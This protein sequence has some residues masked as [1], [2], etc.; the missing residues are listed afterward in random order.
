MFGCIFQLSPCAVAFGAP[1]VPSWHLVQLRT[2]CGK[3]AFEKS[4]PLT[5]YGVPATTLGRLEPLWIL[6]IITLKSTG[7]LEAPAT[8]EPGLWQVTHN[9][10]STRVPCAVSWLWQS[11][12]LAVATISRLV[13]APPAGTKS[14]TPLAFG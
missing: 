13:P 5:T 11:L 3:T 1:G 2:S 7:V 10:V 14:N 8:H 6:W 12:H 9:L 4:V